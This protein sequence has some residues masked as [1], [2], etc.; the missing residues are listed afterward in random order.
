MLRK[1][2]FVMFL[3]LFFFFTIRCLADI[4]LANSPAWISDD[5]DY[6]TGG[7]FGDIDGDLDLD[8]FVGNGNDMEME[9]DKVYYNQN[10]M[11]ETTAS[12]ASSDYGYGCH[13]AV[14]D[15]DN[16]G[17]LD[18]AVA[19]YL[20]PYR[21]E[22]Y[23]NTNGSLETTPSW[24]SSELDHSF[25]LALGDV[26]GDADLDLAVACGESYSGQQER[27]KLYLNRNGIFDTTA[28][29]LSQARY[30]YDVAW[31]D[32]DNDGDLDLA[33]GN[34]CQANKL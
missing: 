9:H 21:D 13:I 33:I 25:S 6:S 16:D 18:L 12:W 3:F 15:V 34:E 11:L 31:G 8:L 5:S 26:D 22:I 30:G 28:S 4:P 14:G 2:D 20:S 23:Y 17:D 29:W 27:S 7:A 10:G 1:I 32:V 19:N 24:K